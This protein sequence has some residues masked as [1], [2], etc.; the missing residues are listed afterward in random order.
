[1]AAIPSAIIGV[2]LSGLL[3]LGLIGG[4]AYLVWSWYRDS[5]VYHQFLDRT[6]FDPNIGLNWHTALLAIGITLLAWALAGGLLVRLSAALFH[7]KRPLNGDPH[8]IRDGHAQRLERPDGT[9]LQIESYGPEDAPPIILTHGWG[10]NSTEWYYLR[11]LL[12]DRFRLIVWDLPGVGLSGRSG[13]RDYSL[14]AFA[15]HLDAVL[16]FAGKPAILLGH[17]IGGMTILTFC[18]LFPEALGERVAGLALVHTTYINPVRT[19][20]LAPLYTALERPLI[21]PLLHLTVALSPLVLLMNW[22][23]YLNGM[24]H[25]SNQ[26]S[27]FAG[28]E[29]WS[30]VEFVTRYNLYTSPAVLARGMLGMLRYDAR[31]GLPLIAI[32]TLI[33]PGD[34]DPNCTPEASE[35]IHEH[36]G[37]SQL[38]PLAP[39][40]HMGHFEHNERFAAL[41]ADFAEATFQSAPSLEAREA[42]R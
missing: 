12:S 25:V 3:S 5:W 30:Q 15:G 2:W 27:G 21:A 28:T 40:K 41:V 39:A 16:R 18:R 9:V 36:V 6:V 13:A 34:R 20:R 24:L 17:S 22:L 23:G 29:S 14:E 32:P 8:H 35:Y 1:M 37:P 19:A 26:Q 7:R 11:R 10:T 4:G 33:V 42:G 31:P 38:A